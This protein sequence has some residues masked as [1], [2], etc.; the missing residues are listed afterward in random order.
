MNKK[1]PYYLHKMRKEI[2]REEIIYE[3]EYQVIIKSR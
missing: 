1:S 2:D 3:D